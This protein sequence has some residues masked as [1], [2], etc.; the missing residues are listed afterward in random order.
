M[1]EERV[2]GVKLLSEISGIPKTEIEDMW[3]KTKDQAKRTEACPLHELEL[4][5]Q[6]PF[7]RY[8]CKNCSWVP[9]PAEL[10][11]YE[12]GLK[13]GRAHAAGGGR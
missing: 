1:T 3:T 8:R 12:Q 4:H 13:H 6:K 2:D 7:P 11:R 5:S 10:A 9:Q